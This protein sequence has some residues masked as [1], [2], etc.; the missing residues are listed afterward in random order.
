MNF[1]PPPARAVGRAVNKAAKS[2][3]I[4]EGQ[5][6]LKLAVPLATAQMAQFAV[7]FVDT[8]MIGRL[9]T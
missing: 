3:A 1:K 2:G 6:F 7:S 4:T 8:I 5:A 9:G